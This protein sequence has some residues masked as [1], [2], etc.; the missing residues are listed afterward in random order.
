MTHH[1]GQLD[2]I[3]TTDQENVKEFK[4]DLGNALGG[5]LKNPVGEAA[6]ELGDELTKPFTGR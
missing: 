1:A 4:K 3:P 2:K 5:G 6:G